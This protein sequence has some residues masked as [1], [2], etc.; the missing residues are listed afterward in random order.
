[1]HARGCTSE[2]VYV[3]TSVCVRICECVNVQIAND[4]SA[5]QWAFVRDD[6]A[7]A[8]MMV[9]TTIP[10]RRQG[11]LCFATDKLTLVQRMTVLSRHYLGETKIIQLA[12]RRWSHGSIESLKPAAQPA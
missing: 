7:V 1:M 4:A 8:T 2:Y 12:D 5:R 11:M 10:Q 9:V 3:H 6:L